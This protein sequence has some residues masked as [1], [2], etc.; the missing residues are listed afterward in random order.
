MLDDQFKIKKKA[1]NS[2]KSNNS[3][4]IRINDKI[5]ETKRIH[6][7]SDLLKHVKVKII[8]GTLLTML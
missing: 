7:R 5:M 6:I 3:R 8:Y 2:N 4:I 1:N